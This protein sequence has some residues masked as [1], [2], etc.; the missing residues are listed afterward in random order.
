MKLAAVY[1]YSFINIYNYG[2]II[3]FCVI[4]LQILK[5]FNWIR[6]KKSLGANL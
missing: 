4:F 1:P 5:D 2:Y 6:L 3:P